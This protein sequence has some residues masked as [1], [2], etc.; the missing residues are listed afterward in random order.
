MHH[1]HQ[2]EHASFAAPWPCSDL[3]AVL[4]STSPSVWTERPALQL[5]RASKLLQGPRGGRHRLGCGHGRPRRRP[6]SLGPSCAIPWPPATAS[7]T[8]ASLEASIGD[9]C[10]ILDHL[11]MTLVG[12]MGLWMGAVD[13]ALSSVQERV[14]RREAS[15]HGGAEKLAQGGGTFKLASRGKG[16]PLT[17]VRTSERVV[18]LLL[19][20][21]RGLQDGLRGRTARSLQL[22]GLGGIVQNTS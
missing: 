6:T 21:S 17:H 15:G 3:P 8:V 13:S 1:I 22:E 12:A 16:R 10:A 7:L 4:L 11:V 18:H 5:P 19:A 9:M 14:R 2:K 20:H